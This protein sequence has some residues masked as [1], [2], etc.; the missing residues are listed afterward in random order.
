MKFDMRIYVLVSSFDPLTVWL[1]REGFGR[2][3]GSRFSM[4]EEDRGNNY[5]HL[6]NVAVQ[7]GGQGYDDDS[8]GKWDIR[9]IKLHIASTRGRQAAES[10]MVS[11]QDAILKSLL[12]VQDIMVN[13][14]TSFALYGFDIMLDS[15]LRAWVIEVNACP[16]LTANTP[17]DYYLKYCM[18]SDAMAI[19]DPD[20]SRARR[21]NQVGCWDVLYRGDKVVVGVG[22]IGRRPL[23][24][25]VEE[26]QRDF[27]GVAAADAGRDKDV[28]LIGNLDYLWRE[29]QNSQS[30]NPSG[31]VKPTTS[32]NSA[33][34]G[35]N[36]LSAPSRS[37]CAAWLEQSL[38]QDMY[39]FDRF[40]AGYA[41]YPFA[42]SA[43]TCH[44]MAAPAFTS[45]ADA[46][47]GG[48]SMFSAQAPTAA[49]ASSP[50]PS[51]EPASPLDADTASPVI[52]PAG[53]CVF[54]VA[55]R[56]DAQNNARAGAAGSSTAASS[57][58]KPQNNA[59]KPSPNQR[60]SIEDA[61][62][63]NGLA[64][65][66]SVIPSILA[67]LPP[68]STSPLLLPLPS[69]AR[70]ASA[71]PLYTQGPRIHA[72]LPMSVALVDA[73]SAPVSA[74]AQYS[75]LGS[76]ND[77]LVQLPYMYAAIDVRYRI[78]LCLVCQ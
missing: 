13:D 5:V 56:V 75:L 44:V 3:S 30:C 15:D 77:R 74:L 37:A 54:G 49:A 26:L 58:A 52:A 8:G 2:F 27:T 50:G 38:P 76:H 32:G 71:L 9:S 22:G 51:V 17:H 23:M 14:E 39:L 18:L 33:A 55:P 70:P 12:S 41:D 42:R 64:I 36:Q 20:G 35:N 62:I 48:D 16:S 6:T 11:I 29:K 24:S 21:E 73:A 53:N 68:Y 31:R 67:S 61:S 1:C 34:P 78:M 4:T 66:S 45:S 72:N 63:P 43:Q 25:V 28:R 65:A 60:Q 59:K 40:L 7:K 69:C 47:M 19:I 10:M 46:N 57:N